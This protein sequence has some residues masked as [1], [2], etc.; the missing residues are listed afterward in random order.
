MFVGCVGQIGERPRDGCRSTVTDKRE[1]L[2]GSQSPVSNDKQVELR[3]AV[4]CNSIRNDF[5][6]HAL[7]GVKLAIVTTVGLK[8]ERAL[9]GQGRWLA[10]SAWCQKR[11]FV[12]AQQLFDHLVGG[13]QQPERHV[14]AKRTRGFAVDYEP[15][16]GRQSHRQIGWFLT[17]KDSAGVD[18]DQVV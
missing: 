8:S 14:D 6:R 3:S 15:E 11:P 5:V 18:A 13:E 12:A 9:N 1:H 7:S 16:L 4:N 10:R 17:L 2:A